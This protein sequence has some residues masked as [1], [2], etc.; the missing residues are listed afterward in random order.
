MK[1][2]VSI[3]IAFV[4][5]TASLT[6]CRG[7]NDTGKVAKS[8][9]ELSTFSD[10][11]GKRLPLWMENC[12][13]LRSEMAFDKRMT[14]GELFGSAKAETVVKT[15]SYT[16]S[17]FKIAADYYQGK[18][19]AMEVTIEFKCARMGDGGTCFIPSIKM[20]SPLTFKTLSYSCSSPDGY[21]YGECLG[22]LMNV[23]PL[24]FN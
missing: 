7:K 3:L 13:L 10:K 15:L 16:D 19:V 18:T 4:V 1:K 2:L 6:S 22:L 24:L 21:E 12:V 11:K 14:V 23:Q 5:V 17:T 9:V 20:H 8:K